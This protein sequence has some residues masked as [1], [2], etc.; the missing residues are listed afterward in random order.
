MLMCL[1]GPVNRHQLHQEICSPCC[2]NQPAC[3]L[4]SLYQMLSVIS[5]VALV[6]YEL[7]IC[8]VLLSYIH[9]VNGVKLADILFSLLCVCPCVCAH[10]HRCSIDF[11]LPPSLPSLP[12]T[13]P[14]PPR[15]PCHSLPSLPKPI[16]IP[17]PSPSPTHLHP[18]TLLPSLTRLL[19]QTHI[20]FP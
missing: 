6:E 20:S 10:A 14:P 18:Q 15:L 17:N 9:Q 11:C 8:T 19:P 4:T 5:C 16:S 7:A 2:R 12:F 3:L 13:S 1:V